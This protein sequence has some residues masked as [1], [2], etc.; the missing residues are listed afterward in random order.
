MSETNHGK[1][2]QTLTSFMVA[3]SVR[4]GFIANLFSWFNITLKEKIFKFKSDKES[5]KNNIGFGPKIA[6]E[7][8]HQFKSESQRLT[9]EKIMLMV[10]GSKLSE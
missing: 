7:A 9:M 6:S 8:D 3:K 5:K 4:G 1:T 10:H 2:W